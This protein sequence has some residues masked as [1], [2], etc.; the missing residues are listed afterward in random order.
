MEA[1]ECRKLVDMI[2]KRDL[3]PSDYLVNI[4]KVSHELS[5]YGLS[6]REWR[7][8]LLYVVNKEPKKSTLGQISRKLVKEMEPKISEIELTI[9]HE[10]ET[11]SAKK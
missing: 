3:D 9:D 6:D 5:P 4:V 1:E 10:K 7:A 11:L 8:Y 2:L